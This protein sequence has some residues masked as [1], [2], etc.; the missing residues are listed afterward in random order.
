[1]KVR[2]GRPFCGLGQRDEDRRVNGP[3]ER[4]AG[5]CR[6]IPARAVALTP[7]KGV[8]SEGN[9]EGKAGSGRAACLGAVT[10]ACGEVAQVCSERTKFI[11]IH[12]R[13]Q[14]EVP[15]GDAWETTPRKQINK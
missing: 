13:G 1:M 4:E 8:W 2:T 15:R 10:R 7:E 11:G 5:G 9:R 6:G 3:R 12:R 14:P